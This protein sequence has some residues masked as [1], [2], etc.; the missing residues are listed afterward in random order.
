MNVWVHEEYHCS[1]GVY[2]PTTAPHLVYKSNPKNIEKKTNPG[3][4]VAT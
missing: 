2:E 1:H 4:T 3:K